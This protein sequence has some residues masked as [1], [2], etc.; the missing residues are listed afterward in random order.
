MTLATVPRYDSERA[1][2]WGER[3]PEW[4]ERAVVV[5]AGVAGL[6]AARVLADGF[7]EVVVVERDS[8]P[9][10]P[11]ARR[12]VPQARHVHV[13]LKGGESTIEDLFLGY[14][15]ELLSSGGVVFDGSRDVHFYLEGEYLADGPQRIPQYG[16]T[17]SLYEQLLRRRVADLDG[18]ELRPNCR[19]VDYRLDDRG[20]TVTGVAVEDE[21]SGGAVLATDLVVDAS[22]RTSRTPAWLERIGY[23]SPPVDEVYIDLAYS[24]TLIERPP[25][26]RRSYVVAAS[27]AC[28]RGSG[29]VPIEGDQW[30]VTLYGVHGERPPTTFEE[31]E[32]YA[33]TLPVSD[34]ADILREHDQTADDVV[35][36]RFPSNRRRRYEDLDR[37]PDGLVVVGDAIASFNPIYA[38]GMSVA[39]LEAVLLHHALAAGGRDD[40]ARRFFARASD[41]VDIAWTMA[42]GGDFQF[43]ETTG[44]KPRGND[45]VGRYLSRLFRR[46]HTDGVLRDAHFRVVMM[47]QPPTTL[48]RPA[49]AWRVLKPSGGISAYRPKLARVRESPHLKQ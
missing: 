22:G 10:E 36:Y 46:A 13:L 3:A 24:T 2:E 49:I 43:P 26:E 27:P 14:G 34:V 25:S 8:L 29:M 37:F 38:Q 18:V 1:S 21:E 44:P 48:F 9:D 20:T 30:L 42:V 47:E 33:A 39:S 32:A 7:D 19:V 28:P 40:L 17:R 41:V 15:E 16:A 31:F 6:L 5:G 4:G 11:V 45:L 23:E 12:G 35:H